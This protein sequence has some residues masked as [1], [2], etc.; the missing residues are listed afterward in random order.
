MKL[1]PLLCVVL[2]SAQEPAPAPVPPTPARAPAQEKPAKIAIYDA[3]ADA[4]ADIAAALARAKDNNRRVLIQWGANGNVWCVRLYELAKKDATIA[5]TLQYEY[6]VVLVDIGAKDRNMDLAQQYGADLKGSSVPYL[7]VLDGAGKVLANQD[8]AVLEDKAAN[9]HDAAKLLSFLR[10]KQA[11]PLKALELLA[12]AQAQALVE[13]KQVFLTFGAPW[14]GW[15]H[16]LEHWMATPLPKAL[17]AKD[18]V[19]SKIDVDRT[20]GGAELKA[21]Q[22]GKEFG[23]PWFCI[24]DA[25]GKLRGVSLDAEG[26]NIGFPYQDGEIMAFATLLSN[27]AKNLSLEDIDKLQRSLVD[28]RESDLRKQQEKERK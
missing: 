16:K 27:V 4:R 7:T 6:D 25:D 1:I 22:G 21:R 2:L 23:L 9:V 26:K 13:K 19:I 14:C 8:T 11:P 18:F 24:L 20:L 5:K 3:G 17:L 28:V 15:C 12:A 10:S